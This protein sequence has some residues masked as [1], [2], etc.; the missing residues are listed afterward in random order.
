MTMT[1][2]CDIL[3]EN[4]LIVTVDAERRVWADGAIAVKDGLV[5]AIGRTADIAPHWAPARRIDAGGGVVHPGFIDGHY[6]AGLHLIR[7]ALSDDP[8][9]PTA[10][11]PGKPGPFGRWLN[12]L[13]EADERAASRLMACELAMNGFTGF[14][15][16]ATAFFPDV[17]ADAATEVGIRSSVSDC[18][19]W[20]QQ[21]GEPMATQVPRAPC[22]AARA[23]AGLGGQ[24][25]R[26][27]RGGLSRGHVAV[28]GM[29][30][31]SDA[32]MAEAKRVADAAGTVV[33]QHQSFTA[34]DAAIDQARFGKPAL[35]HFAESGLIGPSSVFTHMNALSEAEAEAVVAS[36]MALV[37]H[38]GN[39]VYYG[40]T[41]QS[42]NRFPAMARAGTTVAFGTDVAK[43]WSFGDLGIIGYLMAR[44]W[45]DY[46]PAETIL[47]MFTR[48]GA[49]AMGMADRLGQLS[50]G[51]PADLVIRRADL[52]EVQ[53][54]FDLV[55]HLVLIQ[56]SKGVATVICDGRVIVSD[57]R[58]VGVDLA[59]VTA[60][61]RA[62]ARR[63]AQAADLAP[64]QPWRQDT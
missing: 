52:P 22:D 51:L 3:I 17:V 30:S 48:G 42:P 29:G 23:M 44:E 49:R 56:R 24:V 43:A 57:G 63:T 20:D 50:V 39:T 1:A 37:W 28:Y 32:L 15:E 58:P 25:W 10:A 7:G 38:P 62:S 60:D 12:A 64:A 13:T 59:K 16:A 26:N 55:R 21:G 33:H 54:G 34:E 36:G 8:N 2:P 19:L 18:M 9:V 40:I 47:E 5:A 46:V 45:G 11:L 41:P 35:V 14:V 61:A 6:H 4:G 53:P 31:A 27:A